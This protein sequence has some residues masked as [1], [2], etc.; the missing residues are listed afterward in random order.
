MTTLIVAWVVIGLIAGFFAPFMPHGRHGS[1]AMGFALGVTGAIIGGVV[2]QA[3]EISVSTQMNEFQN[4]VPAATGAVAVLV[5]ERVW[6]MGKRSRA[7]PQTS[8]L[9]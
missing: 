2:G 8:A 1:L 5:L 7:N 9:K 4:L 3:L 6:A